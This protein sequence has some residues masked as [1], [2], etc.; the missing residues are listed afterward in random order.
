M[1]LPVNLRYLQRKPPRKAKYRNVKIDGY[2][3]KREAKRA[4]D[5]KLLQ[6]AGAIF[7]LQE[8]VKFEL[9]PKQPGERAM[10]YFADFVYVDQAGVRHVED[11][12]GMK[13]DVYRMKRKLMLQ[14]HGIV[15]EEV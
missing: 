6:R 5:L 8:Q 15:I 1:T 2:D 11:V 14:V 3:S 13:T 9:V 7:D 10:S 12:K 4:T